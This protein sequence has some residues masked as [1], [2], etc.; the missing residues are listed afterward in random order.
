MTIKFRETKTFKKFEARQIAMALMSLVCIPDDISPLD[1]AELQYD[2]TSSASYK[3]HNWYDDQLLDWFERVNIIVGKYQKVEPRSID[4][5]RLM[6]GMA[7]RDVANLFI[8]EYEEN[9]AILNDKK[10]HS[11]FGIRRTDHRL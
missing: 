3:L 4:I 11:K 8:T 2:Q 10:C 5:K 7:V 9:G 1:F 6:S